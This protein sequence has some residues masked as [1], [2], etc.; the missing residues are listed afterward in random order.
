MHSSSTESGL[1]AVPKD[2]GR[3][4]DLSGRIHSS[5][6]DSIDAKREAAEHA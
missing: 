5:F 1:R 4:M 2:I 6:R 3:N